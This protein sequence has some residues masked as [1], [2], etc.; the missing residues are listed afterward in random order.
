MTFHWGKK[1]SLFLNIFLTL[2]FVCLISFLLF[3]LNQQQKKQ[4]L[5][6]PV[7]RDFQVSSAV[8]AI[9]FQNQ[10]SFNSADILTPINILLLGVDGRRGD[11][12]PR[13]DAIHMITINIPEKKLT[14]TSI[15]RGTV[16]E[17]KGKLNLSTYL[18]N[19]CHIAGEEFTVAQI[20]KIAGLKHNYLVKVGFSQTLGILRLLGL[21]TTPT[22]QFLRNRRYGIGDNQR[23]HNQALFIKDMLITHFDDF[24]KLPKTVK[25]LLFKT[26]DTDM[27]FEVADF[28]LEKITAS[29][30]LKNPANIILLT[31]PSANPYVKEIHYQLDNYRQ[32]DIWQNDIEFKQYQASLSAYLNNLINQGENLLNKNKTDLTFR[33]IETPFKQRLWLQIEEEKERNRFHFDL[34]KLYVLSGKNQTNLNSLILDYITEMELNN[35]DNYIQ[36]GKQLL[37]FLLNEQ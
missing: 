12:N 8:D 9:G 16:V 15:P 11:K 7:A 26:L 17:I 28:I 5:L 36:K 4:I 31:K 33:L 6:S 23:S 24:V 19:A 29:E 2:I 25:Y 14:I 18:G 27:P 37:R 32:T 34:L 1:S 20:E 13:C 35:E 30:M 10:Y 21:P 22:L 3:L